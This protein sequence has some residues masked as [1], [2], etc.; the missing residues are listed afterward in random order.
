MAFDVLLRNPF[1]LAA[2]V[3]MAQAI[4]AGR[5][6]IGL[7][8]RQLQQARSRCPRSSVSAVSGPSPIAP[9]VLRRIPPTL[10][11]RIGHRLCVAAPGRCAWSDR[12][13]A[14]ATDRRGCKTGVDEVA[15]RHAHGWNLY[16]QDPEAFA[17]KADE[18]KSVVAAT[19][20][21]DRLERS[22]YFFVERVN[23]ALPALLNDFEAAGADEAVLVVMRPDRD[24]IAKV[25][26]LVL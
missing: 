4:S 3:A 18:L 6:S 12:H 23:R 24:A 15:A 22:V 19:G 7:G 26:R 20:R 21:E 25:T 2:S 13:R 14:T 17:T 11:R 5:V 8:W 16:T 9:G 1:I 10:A